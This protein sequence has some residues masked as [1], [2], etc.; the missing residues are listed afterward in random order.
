MLLYL[1]MIEEPEDKH[2]FQQVHDR[3]LGLMLHAARRV[4][5]NAQDAEDAVQEAFSAI[6]KNISKN[7]VHQIHL[8]STLRINRTTKRM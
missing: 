2:K 8:F 4:L 3:Y 5:G 6:A 1:Q 7:T